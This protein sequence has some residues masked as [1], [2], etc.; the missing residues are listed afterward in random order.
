MP[1]GTAFF[2]F[3]ARHHAHGSDFIVGLS[4]ET[5]RGQLSARVN[6]A[7]NLTV[8]ITTNLRDCLSNYREH[9]SYSIRRYY[10]GFSFL[11]VLSGWGLGFY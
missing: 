1:C 5:Q 2:N 11:N 3:L 7:L 10:R 8:P 4:S 6:T 9:H